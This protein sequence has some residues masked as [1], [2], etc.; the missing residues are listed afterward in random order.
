MGW[1]GEDD[2][3]KV[4]KTPDADISIQKQPSAQ[5]ARFM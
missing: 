1:A 5:L 4:S 2:A 3:D